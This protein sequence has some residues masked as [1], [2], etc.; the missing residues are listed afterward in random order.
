MLRLVEKTYDDEDVQVMINVLKSNKFTMGEKV[1]EFEIE[2][3]K[4]I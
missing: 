4:K 1:K 3:S 2:F